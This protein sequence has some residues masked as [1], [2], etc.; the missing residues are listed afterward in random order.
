MIIRGSLSVLGGSDLAFERLSF[1]DPI[2][3][4]DCRNVTFRN[5]R[6]SSVTSAVRGDSVS[7]LRVT[8]GEFTGFRAAALELSGCSNVFLSANTFDNSQAPALRLDR[9]EAI[10][11]SDYNAYHSPDRAW[12]VKGATV[13]LEE[14]QKRHDRYSQALTPD[15]AVEEGFPRLRN[16]SLFAA[17]GPNGSWLGFYREYRDRELRVVGPMVHSVTD[18]TAN[19]EWWTSRPAKVAV[20]W[21]DSPECERTATLNAECFGTFSM[22]GL[23]PGKRYYFRI[24]SADERRSSAWA[25][26]LTKGIR[27]DGSLLKFKTAAEA[28]EPKV[29]YVA[30]DGDDQNSGLSRE[31]AWRTV[32]RSAAGVSAGDT[33]L[34]A[35]GTYTETVRLRATG[36]AERPVT[37][38]ALPGERVVFDG[39][40]RKI[41]VAFAVAAK[42]HLRFDGLYF[43]MLGNGGWESIF[44]VFDSQGIQLTRC[45]MNGALGAGISPQLLRAHNCTDVLLRN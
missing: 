38:R 15:F 37:F 40:A 39:D 31:Q 33:V 13:T 23:E 6:F 19:I 41:T 20:A 27:P 5:C 14:L 35:G 12:Q 21:G 7:G 43:E 3:L 22:T 30:P 18:T 17:G 9:F 8:H 4:R 36:T 2:Q 25:P 24:V 42:Q 32:T 11:Y 26:P 10:L 44:N 45:F 34:I 16:R 1:T 28:V 29:Y